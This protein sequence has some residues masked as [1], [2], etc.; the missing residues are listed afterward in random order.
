[1]AHACVF[2][3]LKMNAESTKHFIRDLLSIILHCSIMFSDVVAMK[4]SC[5]DLLVISHASLVFLLSCPRWLLKHLGSYETNVYMVEMLYRCIRQ[6][7]EEITK[8]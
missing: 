8:P 2:N 5:E 6:W 4:G 3:Q 7:R 1:M